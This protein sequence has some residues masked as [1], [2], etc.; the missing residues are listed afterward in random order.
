MAIALTWSRY[1]R[2]PFLL[3]PP[4]TFGTPRTVFPADYGWD[5]WVV[6]AVWALVVVILYP[7]CL[8]FMRLKARRREWWLSYL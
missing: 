3:L 8:W 6:Y 4:P 2:A 7:V 5:L 1:G